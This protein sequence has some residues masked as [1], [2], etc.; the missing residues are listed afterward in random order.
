MKRH[1]MAGVVSRVLEYVEI[2]EP[3]VSWDSGWEWCLPGRLVS[4]DPLLLGSTC[5]YF[6]RSRNAPD[7]VSETSRQLEFLGWH[8]LLDRLE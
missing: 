8:L 2:V 4:M 7:P 3:L 1:E 6:G 5:R